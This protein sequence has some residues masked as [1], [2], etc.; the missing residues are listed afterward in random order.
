MDREVLNTIDNILFEYPF[1]LLR[2]K[3]CREWEDTLTAQVQQKSPSDTSELSELGTTVQKS[4]G[5]DGEQYRA[6][7]EW[8]DKLY[9]YRH[10]REIS[11]QAVADVET[12]L[13]MLNDMDR[14]LV[15]ERFFDGKTRQQSMQTHDI[16]RYEYDKRLSRIRAVVGFVCLGLPL[17]ERYT[18]I[19]NKFC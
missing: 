6:I 2:I 4:P 13:D 7:V 9:N 8:E 19:K 10:W 16:T 1:H 3:R 12:V 14:Q 18:E 5:N 17:S 15:S 11:E